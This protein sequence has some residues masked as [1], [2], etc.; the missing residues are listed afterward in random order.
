MGFDCTCCIRSSCGAWVGSERER[1]EKPAGLRTMALVALGSC[2]FTMVG[3]AFTSNTGDAG[4]VAA[5]I[6]TGIGF[7]GAGVLIRGT[8]GGQGA[9]TAATIWIVAGIGMAIGAGYVAGGIG[10]ALLTRG[11]LSL[12][13]RWEQ[14]HFGAKNLSTIGLV[15]DPDHGKTEIKIEQ[16]LAEFAIT[17]T[18]V[19]RSD[20]A[21]G[22][23]RWL[24]QF[25]LTARHAREFLSEA[26]KMPEVYAIER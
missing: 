10:L 12:A 20:A 21:D 8:G 7:L 11:V 23:E 3:Y 15:F 16:L 17:Y 26:A 14:I 18:L 5:Q 24:I 6:V 9:T 2:A 25:Q 13:G 4:R 19:S 1:R 22:R